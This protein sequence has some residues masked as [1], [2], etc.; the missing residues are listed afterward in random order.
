MPNGLAM[1]AN[2][3]NIAHLEVSLINNGEGSFSEGIG[4]VSVNN[5]Q[6]ID[7]IDARLAEA[8]Y[9]EPQGLWVGFIVAGNNL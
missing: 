4:N 9:R 7:F 2:S 3:F 5:T 6:A 8:Q 1:A